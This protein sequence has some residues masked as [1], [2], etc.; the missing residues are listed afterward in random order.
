MNSIFCYPTRAGLHSGEVTAGVLRGERARFQL[1][2]D[3][4]NTASRM[5][6]NG[7]QG[8]IHCSQATADK[9]IEA[10]RAHWL[11]R[12]N[13]RIEAKGK[14]RMQ[15]YWIHP[16]AGRSS[17]GSSADIDDAATEDSN[18]EDYLDPSATYDETEVSVSLSRSGSV[19]R[20]QPQQAQQPLIPLAD[21][22][23]NVSILFGDIPG[24]S[25]WAS[26]RKPQD[27]INL[28]ET[29]FQA[30]DDIAREL[31]VLK[32]ET[33]GNCYLAVVGIPQLKADH[34]HVLMQFG[35]KCMEKLRQLMPTLVPYF[36]EGTESLSFRIGI[37]S[38]NV[39]AGSM[40]TGTDT[41]Q[42]LQVF[43]RDVDMAA[44]LQ[45]NA[46]KGE[47]HCSNR[48]VEILKQLGKLDD[49]QFVP[50]PPIS[51]SKRDLNIQTFVLKN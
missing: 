17:N 19:R 22:F 44:R 28:L 1:F 14:G 15:T 50:G 49:Y 8:R 34:A 4:V 45:N 9:L 33:I 5:E 18:T 21:T 36:G 43:G 39:V 27:I 29:I 38:G 6:S 48:T 16:K 30:F 13:T 35:V 7:I 41:P 40:K 31:G 51:A 32:V 11:T 42:R 26:T 20:L 2:G 47:I 10:D 3:T 23:E 12:R 37:H 25:K 46:G 24:F